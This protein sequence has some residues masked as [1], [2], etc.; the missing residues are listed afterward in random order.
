MKIKQKQNCRG[1]E[2]TPEERSQPVWRFQGARKGNRPAYAGGATEGRGLFQ[3]TEWEMDL[4]MLEDGGVRGDA[5]GTGLS[6]G[7]RRGCGSDLSKE[8]S[9]R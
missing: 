3:I 8:K 9:K 7:G 1:A 5:E 4:P 6:Q 2:R